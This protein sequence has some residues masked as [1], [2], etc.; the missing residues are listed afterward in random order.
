MESEL[1]VSAEI[2]Y[3]H[4]GRDISLRVHPPNLRS[5][6]HTVKPVLAALTMQYAYINNMDPAHAPG[7]TP[8]YA[9]EVLITIAGFPTVYH[10][11]QGINLDVSE[12]AKPL[13]VCIPGGMHLGRIFYGGHKGSNPKHF[14]AYHL[15]RLG[16][17]VLSLSY[18][19]ET[20]PEIMPATASGFRIQDWG[21][22]AAMTTKN[23]IED[24]DL[25]SRSIILISWSMGGRMVVPFK[26]SAKEQGLEVCQ[27]ISFAA[28]PG[29]SSIR[30]L[31]PG[32]VCSRAG[33]FL[34]PSRLDAFYRQIQE[35]EGLNGGHEIIPPDVYRREYIGRTP[36]NLI[37]MGLKYDGKSSFV[38][39]EVPHEEETKVFDVANFPFITA[40]YPISI[41][42]AS[43]AL[44]DQASWGFLLT[45]KLETMIQKEALSKIQGTPK[46]EQ[47][48]RHVHSAPARLC[49]PVSGNHFFFVGERSAGEVAEK[50]VRLIQDA[51]AFQDEL[52]EIVS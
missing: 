29:I 12:T 43:H 27:Y 24:N 31:S 5:Q 44:V 48:L 41:L 35:M 30:L 52:L 33:Y 22:Q 45:Y 13:I 51:R 23:V 3:L 9:G 49:V 15:S 2:L 17:G 1:H 40:L 16:F 46:W 19:T 28:T 14:L 7:T 42:D 32:I 20:D 8:L 18:P 47:L 36:I 26:I 25:P 21:R 4:P 6:I 37:G 38:Q 50:V 34:V 39:D 11:Q 10:Y